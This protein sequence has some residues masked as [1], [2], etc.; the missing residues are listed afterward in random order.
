M[1]RSLKDILG[2]S[3]EAIDGPKGKVKDFLFDEESWIIR[4]I[5]ADFG[6]IFNA[7][8]V[9][10]PRNFLKQPIWNDK[11]FPI[12]LTKGAIENCP[13][14]DE[15]LPVSRA[16][17][18]ELSKHYEYDHYWPH[19]Y[20]APAGAGMYFPTRPLRV[21]TKMVDE[22]E[23]DTSLRSFNEVRNYG[24]NTI[25]GK[26]GHL[27]DIIVDDADWQVVYVVVDTSNWK[28][29]SKKVLLSIAWLREISYVNGEISISLHSDTI[30]DAPAFESD[31]PIEASFEE[32]LYRYY[33]KSFYEHKTH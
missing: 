3:I 17:E 22:K 27:E 13:G 24:I 26:L 5:E 23:L 6:N 15:K 21:P 2:F 12:D 32:S 7:K 19:S 33:N 16:Y 4:Y 25:D 14:L 18:M 20:V 29:W 30:K 11:Q 9:L 28:P 31:K 10:I 8:K 1:K